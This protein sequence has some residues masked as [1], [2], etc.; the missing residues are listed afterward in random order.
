MGK[1]NGGAGL[2][3]SDSLFVDSNNYPYISG[4]FSGTA[5]FNPEGT[6]NNLISA[7]NTDIFIAKFDPL[8]G[9]I[10]W[11]KQ[12]GGINEDDS[13][14][15]VV[16]VNNNNIYSTGFFSGTVDFDPSSGISNL[17]SAGSKT[18]IYILKLTPTDT[19]PE[20]FSF[21]DQIGVAK[22]TVAESN[23]II[24][25]G[26]NNITPISI[27]SCTGTICEFSI[28]SDTYTVVTG[29]VVNGDTIKVHQTSSNLNN[30]I[31][32]LVLN[33]GG[34]TDTF[35]VTTIPDT[36]KPIITLLGQSSITITAGQKYTDLGATALDDID[37]DIT[38]NIVTVN[39]V[40]KNVPGTYII[41]Y[42]VSD[43]ALNQ[44]DQITRTVNV[45]KKLSYGYYPKKQIIN[46]IP[47]TA[48]ILSTET[49]LKIT[50]VL[51]YKMTDSEVR[52]LQIYLNT[53]GYPISLTGPGSLGHETNYF[54][55]LTKA[56]VIKF[57]IA[58]HLV[59]DGVVGPMTR[60]DM[61]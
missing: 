21:T 45:I 32:N 51:K 1:T 33:I 56:A 26:I 30:T 7:G 44:A 57:Q 41:T 13:Q 14:S 27:D 6:S 18:D 55:S 34:V 19:I 5:N 20:S 24:V 50:K 2:D 36:T 10:I 23:T 43:T 8:T 17:I 38:S 40:D 15:V 49:L 9:S 42:N 16:D 60:R 29:T 4:A 25:S 61:K 28:N 35:S 11:V 37:G 59:G 39:H 52:T 58:N 31:T 54:G 48:T 12:I 46:I 3:Y 22:S 47:T 53:N